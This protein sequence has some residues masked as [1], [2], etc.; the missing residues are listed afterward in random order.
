MG[1]RASQIEAHAHIGL[2]GVP[3][4]NN[5]KRIWR[6]LI[7]D[8]EQALSTEFRQE[9]EKMASLGKYELQWLYG[10]PNGMDYFSRF[11]ER[12]IIRHDYL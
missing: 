2:G 1:L 4:S 3:L 8:S 7:R 6:S 12:A 5:D 9:I 10:H 11:V